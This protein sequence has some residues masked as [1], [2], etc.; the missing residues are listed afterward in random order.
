MP[1]ELSWGISCPVH[2]VLFS[3]AAELVET[4]GTQKAT[5]Q[6]LPVCSCSLECASA[7]RGAAGL[8]VR[9]R[10]SEVSSLGYDDEYKR[11][12]QILSE[13]LR[14]RHRLTLMHLE[15]MLGLDK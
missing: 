13:L 11:A 9:T 3:D 14:K 6:S 10:Q 12:W 4:V 5:D 2:K 8:P 7:R 15:E 1:L